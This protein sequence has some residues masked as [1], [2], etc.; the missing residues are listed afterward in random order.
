LRPR[1]PRHCGEDHDIESR[2]HASE[3]ARVILELAF[4]IGGCKRVCALYEEAVEL[5]SDIHSVE[6]TPLDAAGAWRAKLARELH[7]AGFRFDP[8]NVINRS[9]RTTRAAVRVA[10][11]RGRR[12][13]RVPLPVITTAR[14]TSSSMR[15]GCGTPS[16]PRLS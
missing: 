14:R 1:A 10:R 11:L 2:E 6:Y 8:L 16:I 3:R 13:A 7:E 15:G 4:V 5:P 9:R 12:P